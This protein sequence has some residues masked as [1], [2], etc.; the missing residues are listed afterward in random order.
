M[1]SSTE[2]QAI[3][4]QVKTAQDHGL[5]LEQITSRHPGFDTAAAYAV[6]DLIHAMRLAEGARAVG[7]KIGFTNPAMWAQYGVSSPVWA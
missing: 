7:R 6:A 2:L 5:P 1:T 4:L 3:A